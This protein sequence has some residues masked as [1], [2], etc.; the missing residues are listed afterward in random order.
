[1]IISFLRFVGSYYL[2]Y[3]LAIFVSYQATYERF[4]LLAECVDIKSRQV[5]MLLAHMSESELHP[6]CENFVA[7]ALVD[8]IKGQGKFSDLA[9]LLLSKCESQSFLAKGLKQ[10]IWL[11]KTLAQCSTVPY[12]ELADALSAVSESVDWRLPEEQQCAIM[13]FFHTDKRD[14]KLLAVANAAL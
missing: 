9:A 1:M 4:N 11:A 10:S 7:R 5:Q 12:T 13:F 6:L 3:E 2:A 14:V 8:T